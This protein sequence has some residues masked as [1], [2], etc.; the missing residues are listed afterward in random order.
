[1]EGGEVGARKKMKRGDQGREGENEQSIVRKGMVPLNRVE[2]DPPLTFPPHADTS[3]KPIPTI[4]R[5]STKPSIS[6]SPL[7]LDPNPQYSSVVSFAPATVANLGPNFDFL[8]CAVSGLGDTVTL[9]I[10]Q[11]VPSGQ[12]FISSVSTPHL[13]TN[14]LFNC[15]G[16][17]AISAV[18]RLRVRSHCLSLSLHKGLPLGSDLGCSATSAAAA[19]VA[20]NALF[21]DRLSASELI[22]ARLDSEAKVSG[23]H[24]DNIVPAIMGGFVLIRSYDPRPL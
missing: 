24:A 10:D 8:G 17:A 12:L 11:Q 2:P 13:S 21:G 1:M 23:Y 15:A 22:L 16:I 20:V 7:A 9:R 3:P 18:R 14:P 19:A 4:I 5:C 6:T